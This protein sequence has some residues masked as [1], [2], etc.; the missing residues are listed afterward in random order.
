[1]LLSATSA[2]ISV[3]GQSWS[4]G[5]ISMHM[6][7]TWFTSR[8]FFDPQWSV[9][10][11]SECLMHN[12]Q[13]L[14]RCFIAV[15]LSIRCIHN[16][17]TLNKTKWQDSYKSPAKCLGMVAHT[18]DCTGVAGQGGKL[19]WPHPVLCLQVS[20]PCPGAFLTTQR[21]T[22]FLTDVQSSP[23][24]MSSLKCLMLIGLW[25]PFLLHTFC[26]SISF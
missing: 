12:G 20:V 17:S 25:W 3:S 1:M 14:R 19:G 5:H 18:V 2:W 24:Q 6:A 13:W 22:I 4:S 10:V 7:S 8:C 26:K 21:V 15:S 23:N 11:L 16:C 9:D